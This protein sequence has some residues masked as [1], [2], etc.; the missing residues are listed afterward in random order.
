MGDGS[1]E[2][3]EKTEFG[4]VLF[5]ATISWGCFRIRW[6]QP[7]SLGSGLWFPPDD[8]QYFR[9]FSYI[10]IF[11]TVERTRERRRILARTVRDEFQITNERTNR[12]CGEK[13]RK[14][15]A[16]SALPLFLSSSPNL[17]KPMA[18]LV[19]GSESHGPCTNVSERCNV[20][21]YTHFAL[22][23]MIDPNSRV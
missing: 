11:R 21:P 10:H 20:I 14:Q 12:I 2:R 4:L 5:C 9:Y 23:E 3:D 22:L 16:E 6:I 18:A 1:T 8:F 17:T 19:T 7:P 13:P 15:A